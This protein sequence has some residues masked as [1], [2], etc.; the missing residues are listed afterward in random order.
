MTTITES[1]VALTERA[2]RKV[3]QHA[4][5]LERGIF[6]GLAI[7]VVAA[8]VESSAGSAGVVGFGFVGIASVAI[9]IGAKTRPE[10]TGAVFSTVVWVAVLAGFGTALAPMLP[11]TGVP[12]FVVIYPI[13]LFTIAAATY[14]APSKGVHRG[15]TV[16]VCQAVLMVTLPLPMLLPQTAYAGIGQFIG[17]V[18]ALALVGWRSRKAI[19]D[20]SGVPRWRRVL[21]GV[22]RVTAYALIVVV[23]GL[24]TLLANPGKANAF[25]DFGIGDAVDG[26]LNDAICSFTRPDLVGESIGSGPESFLSNMNLGQVESTSVSISSTSPGVNSSVPKY[27]DSAD[28]FTRLGPNN[29]MDS[30]TLYEIAGLRGL[31]WVNWQKNRD[32]KEECGIMPWASVVVGNMIFKASTY[33]LQ[34]TIALKEYSQAQN[35]LEPLYGATTPMVA[36]LFTNFFFPMGG[37]M[38]T[39]AGIALV[40]RSASSGGMRRGIGDVGMSV[41]VLI[42][43]GFAYGG[44]ALASWANP[45][46]NGFFTVAAAADDIVGGLNS[47]IAEV[48]LGSL[49]NSNANMMCQTPQELPGER[50]SAKG[51]RYSS[52][53]LAESLA[54]RPWAVGQFGAAGAR[55]IAPTDET[56]RFGQPGHSGIV[57]GAG[58]PCYNN[59]DG[60]KDMR[61]YLIAQEG[62]PSISVAMGKCV[63]SASYTPTTGP[64]MPLWAGWAQGKVVFNACDPYHA[65]AWQL[66]GGR[67][68]DADSAETA[69]AAAMLSAYR[70][71]GSM[72]HVAQAFAALVG[73][74]CV[75]IG[76]AAMSAITLGWHAWLFVI[77]LIGPLKL[78][79]GAYPGKSKMAREWLAD[80]VQA[81]VMRLAYGVMVTMMVLLIG[82]VY[83]SELNTGMKI[84]WSVAVLVMFWVAMKKVESVAK[85]DGASDVGIARLGQGA[86]GGAGAV[87]GLGLYGGGRVATAPVRYGGRRVGEHYGKKFNTAV[88]TRLSRA[89]AAVGSKMSAAGSK[90]K[91]GASRV[92]SAATSVAR[93]GAAPVS[94]RVREAKVGAVLAAERAG[95]RVGQRVA[96]VTATPRRAIS[97]V[98]T[99]TSGAAAAGVLSTY[100]GYISDERRESLSGAATQAGFR[101][102]ADRASYL[103]GKV[104]A[105]RTRDDR[106]GQV[107]TPENVERA[108]RIASAR[109]KFGQD[110]RRRGDD[111]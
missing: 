10:V 53:I 88:D 107:R 75:T 80:F 18:G 20:L 12:D 52:C 40:I 2:L 96:G 31:K 59:Y 68:G 27:A 3:D 34:L 54:Y 81:F 76:I 1:T 66:Y 51:Q 32:G 63:E 57:Q 102:A 56:V 98:S 37:V 91:S 28:D 21:V 71:Q 42:I 77:F 33:L 72:P 74:A 41:V 105:A 65:V 99:K 7:L 48:T 26:M 11:L 82:I 49:A 16:A 14:A 93:V 104:Q 97:Y 84:L 100:G 50:S 13:G 79:W 87:A 8:A 62:G 19:R 5:T 83:A 44:V 6:G 24:S 90:V 89:D 38:L 30:Y 23:V 4:K 86:V 64:F 25:P 29:S 43:G 73:T 39:V 55:K 95:G 36:A 110:A 101:G 35:P 58:L 61:S 47:A 45:T 78:I 9:W 69:R 106:R 70:A 94:R 67:E 85:V 17:V 46:G 92:G 103:A 108:R 60:C 22:S 15:W 111:R 109:Y